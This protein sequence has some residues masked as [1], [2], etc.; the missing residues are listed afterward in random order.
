MSLVVMWVEASFHQTSHN[1]WCHELWCN[2]DRSCI[3]K[4]LERDDSPTKSMV[5]VITEICSHDNDD[6]IDGSCD[7]SNAKVWIIIILPL[8]SLYVT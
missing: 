6:I 4:I 1:L 7:Q 5:L 3:K 2:N 8:C